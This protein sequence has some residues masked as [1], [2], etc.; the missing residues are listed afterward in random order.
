MGETRDLV[1]EVMSAP[2]FTVVPEEPVR[3]A[4]RA[5]GDHRIGG[6]VVAREGELLGIFTERDLLN[7]ILD[8]A[9][10]L[11]R[12][13]G[14]VMTTPLVTVTTDTPIDEAFEAMTERSIRRLPVVSD[15]GKLVG[16]VTERDLLR[17]VDTVVHT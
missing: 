15:E 10:L 17:W 3:A 14:E 13:V 8:D 9:G 7:R 1:G 11:D 16:I 12:P 6:V 5:M 4:V 2:V